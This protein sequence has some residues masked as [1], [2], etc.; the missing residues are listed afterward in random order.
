MLA[1]VV[2]V[3]S[4]AWR[5]PSPDAFSDRSWPA[6]DVSDVMICDTCGAASP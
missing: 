4:D 6:V 1:T 3:A 5:L 2:A